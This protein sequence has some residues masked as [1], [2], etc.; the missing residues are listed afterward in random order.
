M[1]SRRPGGVFVYSQNGTYK[2]AD[3]HGQTINVSIGNGDAMLRGD[4]ACYAG[5]NVDSG[6]EIDDRP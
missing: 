3:A 5:D 2:T 4:Y 1:P 6:D